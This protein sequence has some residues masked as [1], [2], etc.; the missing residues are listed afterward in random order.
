MSHSARTA[1]ERRG[2]PLPLGWSEALFTTSTDGS[3]LPDPALSSCVTNITL[4]TPIRVQPFG[5][6]VGG[7]ESPAVV[8]RMQFE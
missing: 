4:G 6:R 2:G 7:G 5:G 1:G 3:L 8:Y